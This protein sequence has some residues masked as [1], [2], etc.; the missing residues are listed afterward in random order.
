MGTFGKPNTENIQAFVAR[1]VEGPSVCRIKISE[2]SDLYFNFAKRL[3][4]KP[5][6]QNYSEEV[7][8]SEGEIKLVNILGISSSFYCDSRCLFHSSI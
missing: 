8:E 3:K 6:R 5:K 4:R 2:F 1:A 7:R